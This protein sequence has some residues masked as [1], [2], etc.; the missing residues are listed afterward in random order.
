[1]DDV[2]GKSYSAHSEGG[3]PGTSM[4]HV[5]HGQAAIVGD[6]PF[7]LNITQ[8]RATMLLPLRLSPSLLLPLLLPLLLLRC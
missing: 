4:G 6:D 3:G 7:G 5:T 2:T 8:V 1:M